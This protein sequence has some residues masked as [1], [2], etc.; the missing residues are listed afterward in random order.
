MLSNVLL[1]VVKTRLASNDVVSG[2]SSSGTPRSYYWRG[3]TSPTG[4]ARP[5]PSMSSYKESHPGGGKWKTPPPHR[6][7]G[8]HQ[9]TRGWGKP[10][11][12]ASAGR[13]WN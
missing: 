2:E 7:Y 4:S 9:S 12:S 10:Y 1:D 13:R 6:H 11:H 5:K 8:N 3:F